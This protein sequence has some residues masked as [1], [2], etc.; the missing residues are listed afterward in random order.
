MRLTDA[1][2]ES[3]EAGDEHSRTRIANGAVRGQSSW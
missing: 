3:V 2:Q 1:A